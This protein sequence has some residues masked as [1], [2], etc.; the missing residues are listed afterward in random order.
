M[1]SDAALGAGKGLGRM[2]AIGARTPVDFAMGIATGFNNAPKMYGDTTVRPPQEVTG[3]NSGV[4]AAA[5]VS[6]V[7]QMLYVDVL[8]LFYRDLV[9]ASTMALRASSRSR[10]AAPK[11]K[12]L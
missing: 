5:R 11:R 3:F 12:E 8:I 10:Y 7:T 1:A 9:T 4:Q 2:A 6:K